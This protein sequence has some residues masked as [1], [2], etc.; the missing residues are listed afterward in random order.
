MKRPQK[1]KRQRLV[2]TWKFGESSMSGGGM[3]VHTLS[4]CLAPCIMAFPSD[5]L[6]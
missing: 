2:S 3:D 5:I 1:P 4:L 6:L